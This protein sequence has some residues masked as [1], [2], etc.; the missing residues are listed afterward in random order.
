MDIV[1][2]FFYNSEKYIYHCYQ[3]TTLFQACEI[4]LS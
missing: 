1:I 2:L 4:Y 3:Q